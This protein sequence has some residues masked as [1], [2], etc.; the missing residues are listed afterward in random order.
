MLTWHRAYVHLGRDLQQQARDV[1]CDGR[2]VEQHVV[3]L[4][5]LQLGPQ[6]PHAAHLA[7]LVL[8]RSIGAAAAKLVV[9]GLRL[10]G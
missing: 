8:E 10:I 3:E 2:V 4:D 9:P 6:G 7:Q 5:L 1:G